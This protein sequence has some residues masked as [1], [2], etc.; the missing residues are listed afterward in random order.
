MIKKKKNLKNEDI[1]SNVNS[2]KSSQ[3]FKQKKKNLILSV[4]NFHLDE[5]DRQ[6]ILTAK[7][8][9]AQ[10]RKNFFFIFFFLF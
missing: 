10:P 3:K 1:S 7:K 6:R 2:N 8:F 9:S 5:V 4:C